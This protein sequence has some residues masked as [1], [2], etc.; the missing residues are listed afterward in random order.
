VFRVAAGTT[1]LEAL[2]QLRGQ[3]C[4]LAAVEGGRAQVVGLV[5]VG[6]LVEAIVGE[7]SPPDKGSEPR[8][9]R[10]GADEKS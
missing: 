2:E 9:D 8:P 4:P 7:L 10:A 6:D 5:T 1:V 3:E